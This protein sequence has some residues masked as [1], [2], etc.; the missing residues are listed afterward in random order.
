[1]SEKTGKSTVCGKV[2]A[3]Y[4]K[5]KTACGIYEPLPLMLFSVLCD[6][7]DN[8]DLAVAAM[9]R[10]N[11]A[12][13]DLNELRVARLAEI[14]RVLDPMPESDQR[15]MNLRQ[16]L[17]KLFELAGNLDLGFLIE[18][19]ALDA[20]KAMN[21][22]DS[23]VSR[24]AVAMVMFA[25]CPGVTIPVTP[26]GLKAAQG[27]GLVKR[28]GNK[29]QLQKLMQTELGPLECAELLQYLEADGAGVL[30]GYSKTSSKPQKKADAGAST[31]TAKAKKK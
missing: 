11:K 3:E 15:A 17:T 28:G 8:P 5:M 22:L 18:M 29:Q 20:R 24:Q 1:M 6:G 13:I 26:E 16:L 31:K 7:L 23:N 2:L 30:T 9:D 10:L 19:K 27:K 4:R 12:F 21:D 14:A 25:Y